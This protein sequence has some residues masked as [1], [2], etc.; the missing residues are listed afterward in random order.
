M[1]DYNND[2]EITRISDEKFHNM[3]FDIMVKCPNIVDNHV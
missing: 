1:W 2:N 3:A